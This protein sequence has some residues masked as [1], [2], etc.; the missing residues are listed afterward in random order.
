M[1]INFLY[2]LIPAFLIEL[3]R[4]KFFKLSKLLYKPKNILSHPTGKSDHTKT[5]KPI[6]QEELEIQALKDEISKME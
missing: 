1:I 4:K 3:T 6:A 5:T 2:I